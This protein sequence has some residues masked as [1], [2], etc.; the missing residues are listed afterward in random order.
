MTKRD[1]SGK[2]AVV[3]GAS[4][5][6]GLLTAKELCSLNLRLVLTARREARVSRISSGF[7]S[8]GAGR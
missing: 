4:S 3:T 7:T 5:G 2:V 8:R 1:L 6:I